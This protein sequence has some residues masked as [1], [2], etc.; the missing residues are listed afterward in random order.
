[1]GVL[2]DSEISHN[3]ILEVNTKLQITGSSTQ[4]G[5]LKG[6]SKSVKGT[7]LCQGVVPSLP[8]VVVVEDFFPLPL[9]S[10]DVTL[11]V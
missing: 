1:M 2:I 11:R 6:P 3:F 4:Y 7:E 5:V 8:K 10:S 9:G